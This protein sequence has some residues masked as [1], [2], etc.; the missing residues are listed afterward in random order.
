LLVKKTKDKP[1]STAA[2]RFSVSS[3]MFKNYSLTW[4]LA[5]ALV[6]L[7]YGNI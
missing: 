2:A 1:L 5:A 7:R 3:K 4:S 6:N